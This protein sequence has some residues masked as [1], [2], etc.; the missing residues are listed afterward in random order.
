MA[1]CQQKV[2]MD[3]DPNAQGSGEHKLQGL[4]L[5]R[6]FHQPSSLRKKPPPS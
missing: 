1:H 4:R 5:Q 6:V 3:A 2:V